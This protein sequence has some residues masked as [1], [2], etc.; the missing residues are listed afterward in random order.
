MATE[1]RRER[2]GDS[3]TD[4]TLDTAAALAEEEH[5]PIEGRSPWFLAWRRLRRN[6]VALGSL[7]LF[8]LIVLLCAFA[9]I[10]ADRV[11]E[12]T[13]NANHVTDRVRVG[14]ELRRHLGGRH[15]YERERR[16]AR[17]AGD[18]P[19]PDLVARGREIRPRRGSE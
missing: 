3:A 10:Y 5:G 17:A 15:L 1:T 18:D 13:P 9:P 19:R 8:V 12:T 4:L 16:A 11:A 6:W 14:G 7:I 2:A